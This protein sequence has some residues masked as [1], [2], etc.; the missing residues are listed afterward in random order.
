MNCFHEIVP[1]AAN[2]RTIEHVAGLN[3][4]RTEYTHRSPLIEGPIPRRIA[5]AGSPMREVLEEYKP[6]IDDCE[7][8][9]RLGFD[10]RQYPRACFDAPIEPR[11]RVRGGRSQKCWN[12]ADIDSRNFMRLQLDAGCVCSDSEANTE[13]STSPGLPDVT[14]CNSIERSEVLNVGRAIMA[15]LDDHDGVGALA[16]W[17]VGALRAA[18]ASE[19]G[20]S[21]V[22]SIVRVDH[23]TD[24]DSYHAARLVWSTAWSNAEWFGAREW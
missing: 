23:L 8:L 16:R 11:A 4:V 3:L 14:P 13:G 19:R 6:Q 21:E 1:E 24:N 2:L 10:T 18:M 17:R 20:R 9:T 7:V 15:G 22:N 12:Q 5:L